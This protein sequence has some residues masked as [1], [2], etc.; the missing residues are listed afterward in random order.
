MQAH[1]VKDIR[2]RIDKSN[3][4]GVKVLVAEEKFWRGSWP[5]IL[6][7]AVALNIVFAAGYLAH[8][9][10]PDDAAPVIFGMNWSELQNWIAAAVLIVG[11]RVVS[12]FAED[13]RDQA[14]DEPGV[15]F[16]LKTLKAALVSFSIFTAAMGVALGIQSKMDAGVSDSAAYVA[17][18]DATAT[19]RQGVA[20]AAR[21]L[22]AARTDWQGYKAD[23]NAMN[24]QDRAWLMRPDATAPYLAAIERAE[25]AE[26]AA[27]A[28]L[29]SAQTRQGDA[30]TTGGSEAVQ[31]GE[32]GAWAAGIARAVG[33]PVTG[34]FEA[35]AVAL[36][37]GVF[38]AV[39]LEW[40]CVGGQS[41]AAA[42]KRSIMRDA[43]RALDDA[44]A[45]VSAG[46]QTHPAPSGKAWT[47]PDATG[48]GEDT[49]GSVLSM[50]DH[51]QHSDAIAEVLADARQ[52]RLESAAFGYLKPRYGEKAATIIRERLLTEGLAVPGAAGKLVLTSRGTG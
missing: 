8:V 6:F 40:L 15:L 33:I 30:V 48:L 2:S 4:R 26:N 27:R 19:E 50:A 11:T 17:A 41:G 21:A 44:K 25:R 36:G 10:P 47:R 7:T 45:D 3:A 32:V 51:I 14:D 52:G 24:R 12:V 37:F 34:A 43:A 1:E 5:V 38:V 35:S 31:L 29:S 16:K 9:A 46:I 13:A 20:V 22:E 23:A 39:L 49:S 28:R 18:T 42:A